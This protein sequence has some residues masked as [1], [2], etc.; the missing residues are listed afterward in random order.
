MD[1]RKVL[2]SL[3]ALFCLA[4]SPARASVIEISGSA[5]YGKSDL[6][7]GYK[8]VQRRYSGSV[9]LKLTQVSGVQFEYSN[10]WSKYTSRIVVGN[11]LPYITDQNTFY[12]D[13]V[14]SLNWVQNLVPSN[15]IMQP[16]FSVGAGKVDRKIRQEVPDTGSVNEVVQKTKTGT[17]AV[18]LRLFFLKNLALKLEMKTYMPDFQVK[19]WKDNQMTSAGLSWVF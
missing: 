13:Q 7:D 5:A 17:A 11:L 18:G 10:S 9:E 4:A 3:A 19:T 16:Y 12:I 2:L 1:G 8:T 15:W 14:Y 6:G